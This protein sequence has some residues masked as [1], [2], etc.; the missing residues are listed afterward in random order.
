MARIDRRNKSRMQPTLVLLCCLCLTAYFT[1]HT[2]YGTHGLE[3]REKL[4]ARAAVLTTDISRLET[5]RANLVRDIA[6]LKHHPPSSDIVEEIA[7][8]DLGLAYANDV[9]LLRNPRM[10]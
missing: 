1:H 2:F 5:V 7:R 8:K 9:I 10:R 3:A 6:L 4:M